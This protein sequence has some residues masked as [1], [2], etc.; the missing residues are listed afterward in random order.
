MNWKLYNGFDANRTFWTDSNSLEM[1]ERKI[2]DLPRIDQTIAG[3][4]YPITSA[5]A[6]RNH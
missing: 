4:Y 1:Q 3:N 6:M 5:I 2:R